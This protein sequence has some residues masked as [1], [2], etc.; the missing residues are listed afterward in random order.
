MKYRKSIEESRFNLTRSRIACEN[1]KHQT[2]EKTR[3][4]TEQ[5]MKIM[6]EEKE[7]E[8]QKK[9][10]RCETVREKERTTQLTVSQVRQNK[11]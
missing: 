6:S 7:Q 10:V 3:L 1:E 8:W 9:R 5:Y 2:A 11:K 4:Q